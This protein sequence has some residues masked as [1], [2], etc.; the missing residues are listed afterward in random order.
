[1][2]EILAVQRWLHEG[3]ARGLSDVDQ[4]GPAAIFATGLIDV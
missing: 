3:M 2:Q 4:G 1:M